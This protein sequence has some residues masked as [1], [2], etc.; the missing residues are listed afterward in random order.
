MPN[1]AKEI[2]ALNQ[3]NN[4]KQKIDTLKDFIALAENGNKFDSKWKEQNKFAK[5]TI[6]ADIWTGSQTA[7]YEKSIFESNM[8]DPHNV[9]ADIIAV[10]LP[11]LKLKLENLKMKMSQFLKE[12]I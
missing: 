8:E 9:I 6:S 2:E 7:T 12:A 3:A 1:E 5:I 4:L 11:L 10:A